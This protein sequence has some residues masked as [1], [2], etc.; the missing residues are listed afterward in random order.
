MGMLFDNMHKCDICQ[1]TCNKYPWRRRAWSRGIVP[2]CFENNPFVFKHICTNIVFFIKINTMV[3]FQN[4]HFYK[5]TS[6][7]SNIL[8]DFLFTDY[9]S[10]LLEVLCI[11][12]KGNILLAFLFVKGA[13]CG[14]M[15]TAA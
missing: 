4:Q 2:K 12:N 3:S 15:Q 6:Y 1:T 7:H 9:G 5:N 10:T 11:E 8:P 13:S 14:N